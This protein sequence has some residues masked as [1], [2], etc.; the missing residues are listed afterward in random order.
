MGGT[1]ENKFVQRLVTLQGKVGE[2]KVTSSDTTATETSDSS[3]R[4]NNNRD[5]ISNNNSNNDN[6]TTKDDLKDKTRAK[7]SVIKQALKDLVQG[8]K[9][10]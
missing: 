4:D 10:D 5:N 1:K 3:N 2:M 8:G 6:S 7:I 9:G